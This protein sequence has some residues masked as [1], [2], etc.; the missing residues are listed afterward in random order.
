MEQVTSEQVSD[1]RK[2][3]SP[4]GVWEESVSGRGSGR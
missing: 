4:T 2:G 3:A 1:G